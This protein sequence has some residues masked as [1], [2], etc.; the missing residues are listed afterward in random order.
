MD[1]RELELLSAYLDGALDES[2]RQA[3]EARLAHDAPLQRELD[4]LR[5]TKQLIGAL[6]TLRAPRNLTIT[7]RTQQRRQQPLVLS[8]WISSLSA[9]AAAFMLIA[10]FVLLNRA[11]APQSFEGTV[12]QTAVGMNVTP[13]TALRAAPSVAVAPSA[14]QAILQAEESG[15]AES[16]Q[17]SAPEA[18][19]DEA[20][21]NNDQA[22]GAAAPMPTLLPAPSAELPYDLIAP[23]APDSEDGSGEVDQG[24]EREMMQSVVPS[25]APGASAALGAIAATASA[26]TPPV[27][28]QQSDAF[29]APTATAL[30]TL[31]PT[32]S[33]AP[34]PTLT[35]TAVPAEVPTLAPVAA[36][37]TGNDSGGIV[38]LIAGALLLLVALV[39]TVLRRRRIA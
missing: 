9:V 8:P 6:P 19:A 22:A 13:E 38:L 12:A 37:E 27:A 32:A 17:A 14:T 16:A 25:E 20:M 30:A 31:P 21:A 3:L 7:Q 26:A 5:E 24:Q 2:E 15:S 35:S 29:V 34:S 36:H 23:A 1:D 4:L 28:Q 11:P 18:S 33:P 10:G 39:T